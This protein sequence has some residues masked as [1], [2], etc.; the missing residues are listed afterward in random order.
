MS[1][2]G[3][4]EQWK[5]HKGT[6]NL[7]PWKK[8]QSGNPSGRPKGIEQMARE[9]TPQ[10][11]AALVRC[12]D[13]PD[14]CIPAAVA[15]LDR[16]WGRPAQ[17]ISGDANAPLIVDFRWAGDPVAVVANETIKQI[18]A[19][20]ETEVVWQDDVATDGVSTD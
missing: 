6:A 9:Y 1:A 4:S 8:G 18:E 14:R 12:L 16:G 10:A 13:D 2:T 19:D 17:K 3:Q 7:R 11:I 15:I 20:A 5:E